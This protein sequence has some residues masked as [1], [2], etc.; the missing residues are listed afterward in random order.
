M[1][2]ALFRFLDWAR[3]DEGA[4]T[5]DERGQDFRTHL[6][7]RAEYDNGT[8]VPRWGVTL[9]LHA[10]Q[11]GVRFTLLPWADLLSTVGARALRADVQETPPRV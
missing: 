11:G 6:A 9:P 10:T 5:H 4:D 1:S 3:C 7:G 8:V 2:P